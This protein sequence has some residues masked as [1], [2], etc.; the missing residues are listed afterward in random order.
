MEFNNKL[1]VGL[2]G[3]IGAGKSLIARIFEFLDVPVYNSDFEA[4]RL[5]NED[6]NIIK[7]LKELFGKDIYL[8]KGVLDRKKLANNIFNDKIAL[9]NVNELVHPIVGHHFLNWALI[10]KHPYVIQESAI[11]FENQLEDR[12]DAIISVSA[13]RKVRIQ[14][15]CKRDRVARQLVVERIKNQLS[16]NYKCEHSDFCINNDDRT[17]VVPQVLEINKRLIEKWESLQNG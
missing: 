6:S 4:R 7:G 8:P 13:P 11:L 12:F 10:Q 16:D 14:R 1:I 15:V 2:T 3:G 9:K 5:M 17:L